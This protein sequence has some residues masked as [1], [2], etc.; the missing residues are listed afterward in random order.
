MAHLQLRPDGPPVSAV[1]TGPYSG[2][3]FDCPALDTLFLV[4]LI[5]FK[6]RLVQS[7][8]ALCGLTRPKTTAEIHHYHD[9]RTGVLAASLAERASG[10]A[11]SASPARA[12]AARHVPANRRDQPASQ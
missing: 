11:N 8:A 5:A 12:A 2:Q 7:P 1:A 3:G 10:Y 9:L 4:A 6:G